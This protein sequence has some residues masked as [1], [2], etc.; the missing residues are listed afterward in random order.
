MPETTIKPETEELQK[1]ALRHLKKNVK[2]L[3]GGSA[4]SAQQITTFIGIGA[5]FVDD[6]IECQ[7]FALVVHFLEQKI[8]KKHFSSEKTRLKPYDAKDTT[9][10]PMKD[11]YFGKRW[12]SAIADTSEDEL[13]NLSLPSEEKGETGE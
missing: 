13:L 12:I 10:S 8:L 2:R 11:A 4:Y 7:A 3:N 1:K 5:G 9:Q 6:D